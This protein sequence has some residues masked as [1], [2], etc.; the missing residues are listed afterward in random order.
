MSW[1][2]LRELSV[3]NSRN[4]RVK[5]SE[6][7]P[8]RVEVAEADERMNPIMVALSVLPVRSIADPATSNEIRVRGCV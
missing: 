7:Y 2:V 8:V 3:A 1:G 6:S 4:T 5:D